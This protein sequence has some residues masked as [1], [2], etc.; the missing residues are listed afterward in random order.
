[1]NRRNF[2]RNSSLA[3]LSVTTISAVATEKSSSAQLYAA[4]PPFSL[5]EITID[6]LQEKMQ[7]G[8]LTAVVLTKMYLKRIQ[9]IDK[10]GPTLNS[11]I[12]LNPDALTIAAAMDAERKA[13]KVRGPMHGIPIL[14]K[15]NISTG[16]KMMTTAGAM[17]LVGNVMSQDAFIVKQLRASGAVLLGKTNLSEWANFR[18]TRST[19]A[20][21]SR[22]RQT[23]NP[24]FLDR[25]PSGSSSGSGSAVSANLCAIAIGTE[26][27]GSIIS[28]SNSCGIVGLKPTVGLWS[29]SGIIPISATQDTAGPMARSVKDAAI[30]LGVLTGVDA[31][32]GVTVQSEGKT[33]KDYT[34]FCKIDALKGKRIGVEKQY[35][36]GADAV[37]TQYKAAI[38]V[39]KSL[40][41]EIVEIELLK[42]TQP[43][44]AYSLQV[45][46]YEF[47]DGVNKY[48]SSANAKV[49]TLAE[50]IA[51]NKANEDKAMPFFKQEL[52]EQCQEKGGL[53]S[54]EYIEAVQKTTSSRKIIDDL[55]KENRLDAICS[56][57]GGP[58]TCIDLVN[59]DYSSGFSFS[60]P[61]AWAGYPH[62][63][64][65]MGNVQGLPIGFS[66]MAGAYREGEIL[67]MAYAYEQASKKRIVPKFKTV[68]Q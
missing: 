68:V 67:G 14:I 47:K 31:A 66:F 8:Q 53:D 60:S 65:P 57:S 38:E 58:A 40:G 52:L 33:A 15:D 54:K 20:W 6:A 18:S 32:D 30:L 25:N 63:T 12:E 5:E 41:A 64:V 16:D 36:K 61:T 46:E 42:L 4:I 43:L 24:Y 9:E 19:S 1:M 17:A 44:G 29:R 13:G 23:K 56:T 59:G 62:L 10:S 35:F 21:S 7:K 28:P 22:G 45:L 34:V 55:M 51:F 26:T 49:K 50:V 39:L 48:L 37:V 11:I 27:N 3:S 2:I